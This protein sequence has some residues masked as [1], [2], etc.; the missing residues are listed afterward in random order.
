[1]GVGSKFEK[2]FTWREMEYFLKKILQGEHGNFVF[3]D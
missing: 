3:D 1:V 2:M